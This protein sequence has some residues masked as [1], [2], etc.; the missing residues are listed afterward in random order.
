MIY[1]GR[2]DKKE[3]EIYSISYTYFFLFQRKKSYQESIFV[4][5]LIELM[6]SSSGVTLQCFD[7]KL[8]IENCDFADA[9]VLLEGL[10]HNNGMKEA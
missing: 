10:D 1:S 5:Y 6:P 8:M 4:S 3:S 7:E 9:S 2:I